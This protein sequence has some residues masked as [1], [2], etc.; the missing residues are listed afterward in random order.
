MDERDHINRCVTSLS[1]QFHLDA[2]NIQER[3]FE[4]ISQK[5]RDASKVDLSTATLRR[6]WSGKY[7]NTPQIKTLDALAQTLGFQGW[8]AFKIHE[9]SKKRRSRSVLPYLWLLLL[10]FMAG[11]VWTFSKINKTTD[12][13]RVLLQPEISV[14]EG[15][16]ATI[17]F[18]Y[19]IRSVTGEVTIQ[20]SWIP[21]ERT[22]LDPKKQFYTGT[23]FYP[24]YHEAKL[25]SEEEVLATS[26]VHITTPDW[27]GLLMQEGL[28]P[29]PILLKPAEFREGSS[30]TVIPALATT[31]GI[32]HPTYF[33]V[34]TLSNS[35]LDSLSVD[36]FSLS[37][38]ARLLPM[39]IP[40]NC[41]SFS[42]LIK[43]DHGRIRIPICEEGCYG[44]FKLSVGELSV[45]GKTTD[46]SQLS[47]HLSDTTSVVI[48]TQDRHLSIQIG[49]QS[50]F[51]L[52]Y[53]IPLGALK[54]IKFISTG[55]GE[56][57]NVSFHANNRL[58]ETY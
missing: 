9:G 18:N 58:S 6:I 24:D 38:N 51:T 33:P 13:Q 36:Q 45:S 19:D 10:P 12:A 5:I 44:L 22:V 29:N 3:D 57:S 14:H 2:E 50:P 54:V 11:F 21:F 40:Q 16:P 31:K 42:V 37:F 15:V 4:F 25:M 43:G 53:P 49:D 8:H 55:P 1:K 35:G 7:Q 20:L 17:G 27:H 46:L 28:D 56:I 30:M 39:D 47:H 26:N 34:F 23:Y 52:Q 48:K 41:R 32:D